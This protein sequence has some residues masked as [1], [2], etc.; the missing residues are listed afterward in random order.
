MQPIS[1]EIGT[2]QALKQTNKKWSE[3]HTSGLRH[4]GV[5]MYKPVYMFWCIR[6]KEQGSREPLLFI[7]RISRVAS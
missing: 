6:L 1:P 7:T 2:P 4:Y 3:K 5:T